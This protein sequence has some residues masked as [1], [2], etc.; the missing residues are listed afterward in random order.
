[1]NAISKR[2]LKTS[3]ADFRN[4][5]FE[6][7]VLSNNIFK[8]KPHINVEL[9]VEDAYEMR[10][11]FLNFS[12][13]NKFA[14]LT[15]ATNYFS[16]TSELRQLLAS[17]TFTELRFATAIVTNSM[18]NKIIGNFFIKVNKPATPTKLFSSEKLAFEWLT[19][20]SLSLQ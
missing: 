9:D 5:K 6:I 4:E 2:P 20:L 8:L 11:N 12:K 10:K 3:N 13:G 1:M 19:H 18:A 15:D 17:A 14:V 7:F 16:T